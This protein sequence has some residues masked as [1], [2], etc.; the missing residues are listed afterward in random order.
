MDGKE[1]NKQNNNKQKNNTSGRGDQ[2]IELLGNSKIF[3]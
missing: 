2:D 3:Q 1:K